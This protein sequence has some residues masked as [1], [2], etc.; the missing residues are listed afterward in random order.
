M[1]CKT[2]GGELQFALSLVLLAS[3]GL[4]IRSFVEVL[5]LDPG[6]Q[7]DHTYSR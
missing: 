1:D 3:A 5:A 6:F 2:A 7:P 4:L